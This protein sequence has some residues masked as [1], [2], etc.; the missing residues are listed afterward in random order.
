MNTVLAS[1]LLRRKL[2]DVGYS[3]KRYFH[4]ENQLMFFI[5][6]VASTKKPVLTGLPLHAAVFG[7]SL[8]AWYYRH[9]LRRCP[10]LSLLLSLSLFHSHPCS[11]LLSLIHAQSKCAYTNYSVAQVRHLFLCLSL[12]FSILSLPTLN[13]AVAFLVTTPIVFLHSC[14]YLFWFESSH[15]ATDKYKCFSDHN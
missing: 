5:L 1:A 3:F 9:L 4:L 14:M 2:T 7:L 13:Y 8:V 10:S 6:A 12:S 11:L 15:V